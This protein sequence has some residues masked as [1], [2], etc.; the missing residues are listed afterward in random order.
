MQCLP[1]GLILYRLIK[2]RRQG[3]R[4]ATLLFLM[5]ICA[6]I[7]VHFGPNVAMHWSIYAILV[8]TVVS[9]F[10]YLVDGWSALK[11]RPGSY[12]EVMRFV[13]DGVLVPVAFVQVLGFHLATFTSISSILIITLELIVGGLGNL[14]AS[15]KRTPGFR[16]MAAKSISQLALASF[17]LLVAAIDVSDSAFLGEVSIALALAITLIYTILSFWRHRRAYLTA[18]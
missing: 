16:L 1:L 11:G 8:M 13:L 5:M 7:R 2:G 6:A 18:I 3:P 4:S 14:L 9:G 12:K 10:S 17:A 15:Q